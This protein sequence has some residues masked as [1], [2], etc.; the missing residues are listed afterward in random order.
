MVF[1]LTLSTKRHIQSNVILNSLD[2]LFLILTLLLNIYLIKIV[3]QN[4]SII[5]KYKLYI[6]S[7]IVLFIFLVLNKNFWTV[8]K[9]YSY[10]F[11]FL[12]IFFSISF[13]Y[14]KLNKLYLVLLFSFI[15]Y[16]YSIFNYGIGKLDSFPSII[17]KTYKENVVWSINEEKIKKCKNVNINI[18]EY[19]K[20]SY[21]IL[22]LKFK[23][24]FLMTF[25]NAYQVCNK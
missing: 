9:I 7:F 6:F 4:F 8:I 12:F 22:K 5:K 15:F 14:N 23:L 2:Y 17:N 21:V 16:K 1:F 13:N 19:F 25:K 10:L 11:P 18:S 3:I 24:V 20:K